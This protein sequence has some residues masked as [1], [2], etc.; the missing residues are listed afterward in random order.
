MFQGKKFNYK[1]TRTPHSFCDIVSDRFG[2][3]GMLGET[4]KGPLRV[5]KCFHFF[6]D[7]TFD[8]F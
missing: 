8:N 1:V 5:P 4:Q 2:E 7:W 6:A 3:G